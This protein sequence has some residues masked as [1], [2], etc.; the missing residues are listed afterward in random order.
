ML[1]DYYFP[2]RRQEAILKAADVVQATAGGVAGLPYT[3]I[4]APGMTQKEVIEASTELMKILA[5][6]ESMQTELSLEDAMMQR[7]VITGRMEIIPA[8]ARLVQGVAV[9]QNMALG[10][11]NVAYLNAIVGENQRQTDVMTKYGWKAEVRNSGEAHQDLM[12]TM[13]GDGAAPRGQD[14]SSTAQDDL[15]VHF[16]G[17]GSEPSAFELLPPVEK[18][19]F[20]DKLDENARRSHVYY[21]DGGQDIREW[22]TKSA[23]Q[24]RTDQHW[25]DN[26]INKGAEEKNQRTKMDDQA[27]DWLED[28]ASKLDRLLTSNPTGP[29]NDTLKT[30]VDIATADPTDVYWGEVGFARRPPPTDPEEFAAWIQ[31]Q[32]Q[33][34]MYVDGDQLR[35]TKSDGVVPEGA[36]QEMVTGRVASPE[37]A[38]QVVEEGA[39][40]G[41]PAASIG[42]EAVAPAPYSVSG[43]LSG[44]PKTASKTKSMLGEYS[45]DVKDNIDRMLKEMEDDPSI[46]AQ[47]FE[48]PEFVKWAT[49]AF[50]EGYDAEEAFGVSVG[51]ARI[52]RDQDKKDLKKRQRERVLSGESP[53]TFRK[54]AAAKV[55][56]MLDRSKDGGSAEMVSGGTPDIQSTLPFSVGEKSGQW[57]AELLTRKQRPKTEDEGEPEDKLEDKPKTDET[58]ET[59]PKPL[60]DQPEATE[61]PSSFGTLRR[62]R[63]PGDEPKSEPEEKSRWAQRKEARRGRSLD[64]SEA[65]RN[66]VVEEL[67]AAEEKRKE[68]EEEDKTASDSSNYGY[69]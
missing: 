6:L 30:L 13:L 56:Q 37:I 22:L 5:D 21:P 59:A 34:M 42:P 38:A 69:K 35:Y 51:E 20:M 40:V 26:A 44:L 49:D 9:S 28:S 33:G 14:L 31:E 23:P 48:H 68:E 63:T 43:M 66:A 16:F 58:P 25:A 50:G 4:E 36:A 45:E 8:L 1:R 10:S 29:W 65:Q 57:A 11:Q 60:E 3:P 17:K 54:F 19:A 52:R 46:K 32:T 41:A 7:E 15:S 67:R 64:K 39:L 55:G 2:E 24:F 18:Q 12:T 53:A 47:L 62:N 27:D 61:T